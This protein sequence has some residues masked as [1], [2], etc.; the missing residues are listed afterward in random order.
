MMI[1]RIEEIF[2]ESISVCS[3]SK[4]IASKIQIAAE[5]IISCYKKGNK[6]IIFGN[7]GSA[8]DAQ[9]MAAEFVG[10]Y[11]LERKSLPAVAFTTD[12]SII[13]A[14]GNDYGF[15][16]IFSRQAESMITK[17]DVV[18]AITTSGNSKN[19]LNGIITA[20]KNGASII[21]LTG[22]NGINMQKFVDILLDIPSKSTPR[23]QE[24][25]RVVIHT[26]CELVEKEFSTS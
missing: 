23:I 16:N 24:G 21:G 20:K 18:I 7:G 3:K 1:K 12:T 15:E 6:V 19:V 5:T 11:M 17:G 14:L 13:T 2:D 8:A 25:H 26:I 10:R 4:K 9:H 22:Q